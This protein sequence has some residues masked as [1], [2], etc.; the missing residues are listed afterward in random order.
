MCEAW[1]TNKLLRDGATLTPWVS[2]PRILG[3]ALRS[4][5]MN[6]DALVA[7]TPVESS[8]QEVRTESWRTLHRAASC[9]K[10]KVLLMLLVDA[11]GRLGSICTESVGGIEPN[12]E[13]PNGR[14]APLLD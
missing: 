7:H 9:W 13:S 2:H 11:N 5:Q 14:V 1:F 4:R 12:V 6:V 10:T 3:V 8:P